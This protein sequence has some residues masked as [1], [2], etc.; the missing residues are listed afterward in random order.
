MSKAAHACSQL[1]RHPESSYR[2][3]ERQLAGVG[4]SNTSVF[5]SCR[6][7]RRARRLR[8]L[9]AATESTPRSLKA[10]R[11]SI[12][13][14]NPWPSRRAVSE[15]T[16]LEYQPLA[17][18]VSS[19]PLRQTAIAHLRVTPPRSSLVLSHSVDRRDVLRDQS[20]ELEALNLSVGRPRQ[21]LGKAHQVRRFVLAHPLFAPHTQ[22]LSERR[23]TGRP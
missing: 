7:V 12:A 11:E 19:Q 3:I 4:A 18:R 22:L 23:V 5:G 8:S 14:A 13:A 16:Q 6:P 15:Q 21:A 17:P 9:A 1:G 2:D 20:I 10:R